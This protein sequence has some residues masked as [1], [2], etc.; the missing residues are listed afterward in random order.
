MKSWFNVKKVMFW[1]HTSF[2]QARGVSLYVV[3]NEFSDYARNC[4]T[5]YALLLLEEK[6][7]VKNTLLNALV[8]SNQYNVVKNFKAGNIAI[9][10]ARSNTI[11]AVENTCTIAKKILFLVLM[12]TTI[13]RSRTLAQMIFLIILTSTK[14]DLLNVTLIALDT[15]LMDFAAMP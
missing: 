3:R 11:K 7:K 1:K 14:R 15:M 9:A 5:D 10:N 8:E 12:K 6:K 2:F 4:Q 13:L